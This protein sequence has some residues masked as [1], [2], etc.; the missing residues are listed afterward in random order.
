MMFDKILTDFYIYLALL[1]THVHDFYDFCSFSGSGGG[2]GGSGG[3]V[4]DFGAK[5][6][7]KGS[8]KGA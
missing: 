6:E 7:P 4:R 5:M 2:P 3:A 1:Q 8:K